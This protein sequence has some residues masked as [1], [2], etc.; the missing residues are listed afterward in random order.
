M[1]MLLTCEMH[2]PFAPLLSFSLRLL[3]AEVLIFK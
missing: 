2:S 1:K 3:I